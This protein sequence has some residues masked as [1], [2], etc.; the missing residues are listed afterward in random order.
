MNEKKIETK[1]ETKMK[2]GQIEQ[3]WKKKQKIIVK[4]CKG[5]VNMNTR[6]SIYKSTIKMSLKHAHCKCNLN[7]SN[8]ITETQKPRLT[9]WQNNQIIASQ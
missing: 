1:N 8:W 3:I 2:N 9:D 5:P 6:T 4:C 7:T